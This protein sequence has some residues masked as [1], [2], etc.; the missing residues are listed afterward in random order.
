[1]NETLITVQSDDVDTLELALNATG[2]VDVPNATMQC[3]DETVCTNFTVNS[4][5]TWFNASLAER[6]DVNITVAVP[7]QARTGVYNGTLDMETENGTEMNDLLLTVNIPVNL[8]WSQTPGSVETVLLSG[9]EDAMGDITVENDG[10]DDLVVDIEESGNIS[11]H[12]TTSD[13][14]MFIPFAGE[15]R[16][17]VS[18]SAPAVDDY[19]R[20]TGTV[21]STN[22]SNQ[23]VDATTEVAL[24]TIPYY[25]NITEPRTATRHIGVTPDSNTTAR[26]NVSFGDGSNLQHLGTNVNFSVALQNSTHTLTESVVNKTFNST[27]RL[28]NV[29]Y[30]ATGAEG[31]AYDLNVTANHTD[32]NENRSQYHIRSDIEQ[33]AVVMDDTTPPAIDI[34]LP[35]SVS[36]GSVVTADINAT[37][38]GL[39]NVSTVNG[40]FVTPNGSVNVTPTFFER[41]GSTYR[42]QKNLTDTDEL[43]GYAV[44]VTACDVSGNCQTVQETFEIFGLNRVFGTAS[45]LEDLP[46]KPPIETKFVFKDMATK[47]V[48]QEFAPNATTGEY[49]ESVRERT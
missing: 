9:Q 15:K 25:V 18:A 40:T 48:I 10:N 42:F 6:T 14:E 24:L 19:T 28:W 1:M 16:F 38:T 36:D 26:V 41:D 32:P 21:E 17:D 7:E 45:D 49:N 37:D 2:N 46:E 34:G 27:A 13:T 8:S 39:V 22:E 33:D 30:I 29:T 47:T 3:T 43:G 44:N 12:I 35:V 11:Q 20:F 4:T 23:A 31:Y 5:P